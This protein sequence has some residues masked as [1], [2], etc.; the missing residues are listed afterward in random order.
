MNAKELKKAL[1]H[2]K[3]LEHISKGDPTHCVWWASLTTK[4]S[5][6]SCPMTRLQ[7]E[8]YCNL[9][10]EQFKNARHWVMPL[11]PGKGKNET[12]KKI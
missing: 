2:D 5:G 10:N 7:A 12:E 1:D 9:A 6:Q 11:R 8:Y 3:F 4:G